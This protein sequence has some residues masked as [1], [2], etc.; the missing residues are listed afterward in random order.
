MPL[1]M[2]RP[3]SGRESALVFTKDRIW[4]P[5]AVKAKFNIKVL[6]VCLYGLLQAG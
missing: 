4:T 2:S 5:R 3:N 1:N 6:R